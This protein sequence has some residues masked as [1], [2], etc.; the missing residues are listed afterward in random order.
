MRSDNPYKVLG[1]EPTATDKEIK[2]AYR[3]LAKEL[4]PDL[5]PGD[6]K[7]E[8]RFKAVSTAYSILGDKEK[9]AK[10]D[11][12]E[13]DATGQETRREQY[14]RSYAGEGPRTRYYSS[15]GFDD[16]AGESDLFS[17]L[18]RRARGFGNDRGFSGPVRGQDAHYQMT[19]DFLEAARGAKK[20]LTMPDGSTLDVTVPAG[21][22]DGQT[23]RLK[24]KGSPGLNGGP[25]GDAYVQ[26]D[27]RPHR[28]FRS[29][30]N[31]ILIELPISLDEAVLGAKVELP[32]IHGK[33]SMIIPPGSSSGQV[34][35]LKGKGIAAGK[36][37][38]AGDQLVRLKVV[39]PKKIDP[40]LRD[41]MEKWRER[42]S[43]QVRQ[44]L[45]GASG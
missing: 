4:H 27:V 42:N 19:I 9:R 17:E 2:A 11:R 1:V 7:A 35:R 22:R 44:E 43:Y 8:E 38:P 12:G 13:I 28:V 32:T 45:E 15:G 39:L 33:I 34:L 41:F 20:R 36:S 30:G 5:N 31:D 25:A 16:F 29:E 18:F 37:A 26:I 24:G 10:F 14:Y 3:K 40:E 6:P 21:L 23:I